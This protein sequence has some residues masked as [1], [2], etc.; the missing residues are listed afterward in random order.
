MDDFLHIRCKELQTVE[1]KEPK[2]AK[3]IGTVTCNIQKNK[4]MCV[5]V[6]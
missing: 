3:K 2:E 6:L 4:R 5:Y 1:G